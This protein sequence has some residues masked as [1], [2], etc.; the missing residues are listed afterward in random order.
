LDKPMHLSL[1]PVACLAGLLLPAVAL[2]GPVV[3][4]TVIN[5][6]GETIEFRARDG[7]CTG[8][9]TPGFADMAD[10]ARA[11]SRVESPFPT[12]VSCAIEFQRS[13]NLRSCRYVLSRVRSSLTGPWNPPSIVVTGGSDMTCGYTVNAIGEDPDGSFSV[14]LGIE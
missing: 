7:D 5:K 14:V 12:S 10:G 1:F 2:C 3:E 8:K 4:A 11:V 13:D 9:W 6:T